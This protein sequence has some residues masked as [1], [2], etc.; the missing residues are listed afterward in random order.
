M[1]ERNPERCQGVLNEREWKEKMESIFDVI[2]VG[3]GPVGQIL[4]LLLGQ[5]GYHVGVFER[6][7]SLYPRPR[8]VHYDDEVARIFQAAGVAEDLAAVVEPSTT[9][10]WRNDRGETL[11]LFDW[12]GLGSS[13]WPT[14]TMFAQ[15]DLETV[16]DAH[17]KLFPTIEVHQGWQAEQLFQDTAHVELTVRKGTTEH[18]G[19]WS[20]TEET[21]TVQGRY[22]IGADGANSFVRQH[23]D[24]SVTDPGFAFDWLVIDVIPHEQR[25]WDPPALQICDPVRP[26]TVVPGG[27][28]RRRWEFMRL[29]GESVE[30]LNRTETAWRF[31]VPWQ[32]TPQ[33]AT[34]ER[35]TI[36]TFR[37][38][39]ADSWRKGRL[40]LAGDAAHLMP[41]FAGQ[42]MG[43][44]MRD[45]MNL[46]WKLDLVLS[47]RAGDRLLDT[48]TS[49]RMPNVQ[50][51]IGFSMELGKVI[52]ITD[53]EIAA[54][55][56]AQ[57]LAVR[58]HPELAPPAPPPPRLGPG[59][60]RT[61]DPLA[62]LPFIQGK[63]TRNGQ[64]G[65]FDDIVGRGFCL[66]SPVGDPGSVLSSSSREFLTSLGGLTAFL[67]RDASAAAG[68]VLDENGTYSDW[69]T[70]N[71]CA[72][73]L[74]RP[75]GYLFGA[76]SDL[77]DA[78]EL[79]SALAS[80]L[81]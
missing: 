41:P 42:G 12:S 49:E 60:L 58:E 76:A 80:F 21:R 33:N 78:E 73:V 74:T 57:M 70:A 48:Y 50:H 51:F 44:G 38:A 53:P 4:A 1:I 29:P 40:L 39:W 6:W 61:D 62:G 28:G 20:P 18:T 67:V 56:D 19:S 65:L 45:A 52:C 5:K 9:Y 23:M 3:Y 54:A 32:M 72:V 25:E 59:V 68:H 30:E 63:V 11:L 14:S 34:L 31:L 8:A 13:G 27:K 66:M 55:R 26:T 75:D 7:S 69:F 22:L 47:E 17:V 71:R 10:E 64:T 77:Q 35:H 81:R 79:V 36:Y 46:A 16:L 2:I 37:A 24:T 43:A 15:P